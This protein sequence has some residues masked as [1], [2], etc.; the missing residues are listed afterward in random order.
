MTRTA[1]LDSRHARSG[2]FALVFAPPALV[3][4][5][6]SM[7]DIQAQ[8]AIGQPLASVE[9]LISMGLAAVLIALVSVNCED[10]PA[11]MIVTSAASLVIGAFQAFGHLRIP[12]L[13]ASLIDASDMR[14]AVAWNL[15]PLAVTF[16]TA[17]AALALAIARRPFVPTEHPSRA[18]LRAH[19]HAWVA[20][21]ALPAALLV[22]LLYRALAPNDTTGVASTGLS[23]LSSPLGSAP[24]P[25]LLAALLLGLITLSSVYSLTGPQAA[26]WLLLVAPGYMLWPLWT[27]ITG[28]VVTP[29]ASP[30]T[31]ISLA[32]PVIAAL[33][34]LVGA[35][36]IGVYG[37]RARAAAP[38]EGEDPAADPLE[39][40]P[41]RSAERDPLEGPETRLTVG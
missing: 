11:G 36:T 15:Y 28:Q 39:A 7:A 26:A 1:M 31:S 32:S 16:I 12:L 20:G 34:L 6:S 5:G 9:G 18:R 33:G 41:A 37:A 38:T 29:G 30:T 21:L 17:C 13:Q 4:L 27:S 2:L 40:Q 22:A 23:A 19:R 14:A 10:S 24:W 35:S 25:G 3:L 8:T